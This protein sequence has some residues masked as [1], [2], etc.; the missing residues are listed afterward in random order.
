MCWY[1]HRLLMLF[2]NNKSF[3]HFNPW[4][5]WYKVTKFPDKSYGFKIIYS[6]YRKFSVLYCYC[7]KPHHSKRLVFRQR[8]DHLYHTIKLIFYYKL[9]ITHYSEFH[10][11][12]HCQPTTSTSTTK[13]MYTK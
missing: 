7:Y 9:H 3:I 11:N 8:G 10:N 5:W 1:Q 2:G 13:S 12:L 6:F 4:N